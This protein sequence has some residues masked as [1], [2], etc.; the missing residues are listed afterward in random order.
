MFQ[1]AVASI[2]ALYLAG[3]QG[4]NDSIGNRIVTVV[5]WTAV[6]SLFGGFR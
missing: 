5:L 1:L 6:L 2:C 3:N 4:G